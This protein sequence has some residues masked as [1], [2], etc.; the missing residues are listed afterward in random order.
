MLS[1][2]S[3]ALGKDLFASLVLRASD[4]MRH[5]RQVLDRRV[6]FRCLSIGPKCE[7][8]LFPPAGEE[9]TACWQRSRGSGL[10]QASRGR[11][12]WVRA[13]FQAARVGLQ[14]HLH[15]GPAPQ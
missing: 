6:L 12:L 13:R 8:S 10:N 14:R 1:W 5:R 4:T 11:Q 15:S 2:R 7:D 3:C 9:S